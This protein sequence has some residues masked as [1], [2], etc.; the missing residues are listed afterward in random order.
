MLD[1]VHLKMCILSEFITTIVTKK[2][3]GCGNTLKRNIHFSGLIFDHNL[4]EPAIQS[5]NG[6]DV[7]KLRPHIESLGGKVFKKF[8]KIPIELQMC[9]N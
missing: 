3:D 7:K 8:K 2:C 4:G 5:L 9:R 6:A 1:F